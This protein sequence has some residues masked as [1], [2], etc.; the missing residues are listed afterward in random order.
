MYF[1]I[2]QNVVNCNVRIPLNGSDFLMQLMQ[3][4]PQIEKERMNIE[5]L[6]LLNQGIQNLNLK[7]LQE[8]FPAL[9]H[10]YFSN[11]EIKNI[12]GHLSNEKGSLKGLS[13]F[14]QNTASF[15]CP[16]H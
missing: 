16:K 3:L 4:C 12:T 13:I 8:S 14:T 10:A 2:L 11:N 7:T 6:N 15:C 1:H 9:T 5:K